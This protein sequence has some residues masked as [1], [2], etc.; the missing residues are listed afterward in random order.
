MRKFQELIEYVTQ[1]RK[2]GNLEPRHGNLKFQIYEK[3]ECEF[4]IS[5][6]DNAPCIK[7]E[8]RSRECFPNKL[9]VAVSEE[10]DGVILYGKGKVFT[11]NDN[12]TDLITTFPDGFCIDEVVAGLLILDKYIVTSKDYYF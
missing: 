1:N 11:P 8:E 7:F 12:I 9:T 3:Q 4:N 2:K 6:G 10:K 5:F